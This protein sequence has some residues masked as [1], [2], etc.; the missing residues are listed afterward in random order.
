MIV[1]Y[2]NG[3]RVVISGWRAWLIVGPAVL[4]AA[5]IVVALISLMLGIA[6]TIFTVLLFVVPVAIALAL[7][8]RLFSKPR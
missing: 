8:V 5:L 3:E 6:L 1:I 4:V 7:L 2:R